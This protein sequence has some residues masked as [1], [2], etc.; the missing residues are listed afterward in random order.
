MKLDKYPAR[1]YLYV[2]SSLVFKIHVM[3]KG[4]A[5][6]SFY[7]V[8]TYGLLLLVSYVNTYWWSLL[9]L[10]NLTNSSLLQKEKQINK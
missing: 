9:A 2:L 4:E 5:T 6:Y 7:C 10:I 1:S 8:Y 3:H